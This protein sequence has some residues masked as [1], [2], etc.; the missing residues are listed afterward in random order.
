MGYFVA[1][2][3]TLSTSTAFISPLQTSIVSLQSPVN[4]KVA[5]SIVLRST[6]LST[7]QQ[8]LSENSIIDNSIGDAVT[9]SS[10]Q[11]FEAQI[12]GKSAN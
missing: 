3:S 2:L 11:V 12:P 10:T 8:L 1:S 7:T 9:S 5:D 6:S 4:N